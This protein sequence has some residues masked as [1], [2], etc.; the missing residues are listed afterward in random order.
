MVTR[1]RRAYVMLIL[2]GGRIGELQHVC[3]TW[4]RA[5]QNKKK[6]KAL[7]CVSGFGLHHL[8]EIL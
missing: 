5:C 1:T 3:A 8:E 4:K 2:K 7:G 6:N